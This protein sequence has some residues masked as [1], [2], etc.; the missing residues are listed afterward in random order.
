MKIRELPR[1][2]GPWLGGSPAQA[3]SSQPRSSAQQTDPE[4]PKADC[5]HPCKDTVP[6]YRHQTQ[7]FKTVSVQRGVFI[8]V[9]GLRQRLGR[10]QQVE[11]SRWLVWI[12]PGPLPVQLVSDHSQ[13]TANDPRSRTP[14]PEAGTHRNVFS[15]VGQT[16]SWTVFVVGNTR[17]P[18]VFSRDTIVVLLWTSEVETV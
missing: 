7:G 18:C 16:E 10:S 15:L 14:D 2:S 6:A 3:Q 17:V 9:D 11:R 1:L 4:R 13:V 8:P 12:S 5:G